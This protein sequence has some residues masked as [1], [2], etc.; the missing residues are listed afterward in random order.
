MSHYIKILKDTSFIEL[1]YKIDKD[2]ADQT[3][4]EKC[5]PNCGGKLDVA[6]YPRKPRGCGISDYHLCLRFCLCCRN[7]GCR[8]RCSPPSIRFMGRIVYWSLWVILISYF[9]NNS[10]YQQKQISTLFSIDRQTL[11]RWKYFWD[12]Q[13]PKSKLMK[14][15]KERFPLADKLPNDLVD[16]VVNLKIIEESLISLLHLFKNFSRYF[17]GGNIYAEDTH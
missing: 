12:D 2:L 16:T 17:N 6:N 5:C 8:K 14:L 9:M 1:L 7:D 3:H 4:R 10:D 13:F 11:R 15:I